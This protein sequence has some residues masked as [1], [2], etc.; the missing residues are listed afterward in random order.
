MITIIHIIIT[1]ILTVVYGIQVVDFSNW[2]LV[3]SLIGFYVL[4]NIFLA[5]FII[6]IFFVIVFLTKKVDP[7]SIWKH[8]LYMAFANYF[9]YTI[10]RVKVIVKGLENLPKD[11]N[12]VVYSNH[13]EY[14]DPLYIKRY[15]HNTALAF[16]S[17]EP[18]F[19]VPLVKDVLESTGCIPI[20]KS[21]DRA[22]LQSILAAIQKVKDGQAMAL[23]PEGKRSYSNNMDVFKP[24]AFKVASKAKADISLV[25]IYDF[26]KINVKK[27]RIKR[28]KVYMS[29]LPLIKY[30][31][32]KE[33]DTVKI[34]QVAFSKIDEELNY[35]KNMDAK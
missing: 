32:Y 18:L 13:I 10:L 25:A 3:L 7:K 9:F 28:V 30:D 6:V 20:G 21:A 12:F 5:I 17:K 11:Q 29:I 22:S 2:L 33:L 4:I 16:I 15:Y 19:K 35:Y 31:E 24:G 26:H 23:F 8:N 14:N 27:F 34:S 1:T